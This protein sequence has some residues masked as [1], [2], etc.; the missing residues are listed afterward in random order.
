[1][2]SIISFIVKAFCV[3]VGAI[4]FLAIMGAAIIACEDSTPAPVKTAP[5]KTA[6]VKTA[7]VKTAPVKTS[8]TPSPLLPVD[9]QVSVV[10]ESEVN[11]PKLI[12]SS[13]NI[14]IEDP[15]LEYFDVVV[16]VDKSSQVVLTCDTEYEA[17]VYKHEITFFDEPA[18]L[19]KL[20]VNTENHPDIML[21]FVINDKTK[22]SM[23][24]DKSLY[25]KEVQGSYKMT[26]DTGD[27][28]YAHAEWMV[29]KKLIDAVKYKSNLRIIPQDYISLE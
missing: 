29:M 1:M 7:P 12:T 23:R 8:N 22:E 15:L 28:M 16:T 14:T 9:D 11:L 19:Y 4:I 21:E 26:V 24:E 18:R 6:P 3:I 13:V 25:E 10:D 2:K 17:T 5:V 20:T 27:G